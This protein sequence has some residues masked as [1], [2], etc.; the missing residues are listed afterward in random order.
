MVSSSIEHFRDFYYTSDVE[1]R[2]RVQNTVY[3]FS[4]CGLGTTIAWRLEATQ[5]G[6]RC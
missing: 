2:E 1:K 4:V 6:V 5:S 3:N